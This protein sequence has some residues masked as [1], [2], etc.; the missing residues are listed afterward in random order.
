MIKNVAASSLCGLTLILSGCQLTSTNDAEPAV[1]NHA[2]GPQS[3]PLQQGLQAFALTSPIAKQAPVA[4]DTVTAQAVVSPQQQ[5]LLWQRIRMQMKLAIP[6]NKR[7]DVQRQWY[8][9]NP[10]YMERVAK[11]AAPFLYMIVEQVEA[12][13]MPLELALLPI[14]ESAFDPFAYSHGRASGIWQFIPGT[15]QHFGLGIDWWYDGRRDVYAATEAAL[16][17]LSYL[18]K[19]FDGNWMQALAAYNSGEGRVANAIRKNKR[20]HKPTDFWSLDLPRE[21]RAY[22]PK[23]LAL[24]DIL[25]N[26]DA[27]GFDW[28]PIDN[29]PQL[30][31]IELD[32]QIDLAKAAELADMPLADLQMLNAG[33]NRWATAP[34]G[35][36]RLLIPLQKAA[37]FEEKLAAL[38]KQE[39]LQWTRHEVKSGEN[40]LLIAKRYH[41]TPDVIQQANN[42]NGSI[43]RAGDHLLIPV[44]ATELDDYVLSAG[45]RL[46]A[47][48][49][50]QHGSQRIDY[51]VNRGD[52]L[53]DISREYKVNLRSLAKWNGMA[54]TD[55]LR[56]GQKLAIWL[57]SKQAK[58]SDGVIRKVTYQVRNGDSLARIANRFNVTI[59]QIEHWNQINRR[60]Y[61]Q[62]G[63]RLQLFVDVTRV[64]I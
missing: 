21:T 51:V 3:L 31:R 56:P 25:K 60:N 54:P 12:R 34:D 13:D 55:P 17:Y 23:L 9:R 37:S 1:A 22:V 58:N 57:T 46:A 19:Y 26:N 42:I 8:L 4:T 14:V 7:I 52:T 2:T 16:D 47:S 59:K 29:V 30:E 40:L 62:P 24:A 20:A 50:R 15:A 28:Y 41:T 53:W 43:I 61:L 33:Y 44:A 5:A 27:Y 39:W 64:N 38:D 10:H 45:Q 36:H 48:Q 35:P 32:S 6:D 63:Q 18:H 11:R 49:S